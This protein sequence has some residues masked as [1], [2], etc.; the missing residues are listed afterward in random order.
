M[1]LAQGAGVK[2]LLVSV[3]NGKMLWKEICELQCVYFITNLVEPKMSFQITKC[4]FISQ[5]SKFRTKKHIQIT[6]CKFTLQNVNINH[7]K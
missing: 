5:K 7:K 6:K 4:E 2:T 3:Q 1:N